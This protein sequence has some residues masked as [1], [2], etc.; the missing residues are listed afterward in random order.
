MNFYSSHLLN[1]RG[2]WQW[3]NVQNLK[4]HCRGKSSRSANIRLCHSFQVGGISPL[5][6]ELS[7]FFYR[8]WICVKTV[9][10]QDGREDHGLPSRRCP[11]WRNSGLLPAD[12][13]G[14]VPHE[15]L[16]GHRFWCQALSQ[17]CVPPFASHTEFQM[18]P[19]PN[20]HYPVVLI[21]L[22]DMN[23]GRDLEQILTQYTTFVKPAFEE[24]CLPV[25]ATVIAKNCLFSSA[26]VKMNFEFF[27]F[28][29]R[30]M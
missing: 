30:S 9:Y 21:V 11:L 7:F 22:R 5:F 25:S 13:T 24:F 15:A 3:V 14:N 6:Q 29:L 8:N 27:S 26:S 23:R 16:R 28:R 2:F 10:F 18:L 1:F 17:G 12:S 20:D 19:W 4:G